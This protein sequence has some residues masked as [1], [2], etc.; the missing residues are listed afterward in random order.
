[1]F[2]SA[3]LRGQSKRVADGG[4]PRLKFIENG[5]VGVEV[6]RGRVAVARIRAG[7]RGRVTAIFHAMHIGEPVARMKESATLAVAAKAAALKAAGK[8]VIGFGVGE[9]DFDT[10]API[11]E[12]AKRALDAGMTRYAPT[13]GDKAVREAVARTGGRALLEV[14]G[15]VDLAAIRAIAATGV[16]RISVGKLTKDVQAVDLSLR[17]LG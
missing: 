8:P 15:G 4:D 17:V 14:S 7:V 11:R 12:A 1:M 9:P 13:P 5:L 2:R 10:P 3:I 6:H 16:D